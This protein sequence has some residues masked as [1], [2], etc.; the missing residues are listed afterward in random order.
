MSALKN[1]ARQPAQSRAGPLALHN[2]QLQGNRMPSRLPAIALAIA[3]PR[4]RVNCPDYPTRTSNNYASSSQTA[5]I[6]RSD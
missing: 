2:T 1:W 5:Q 4:E 6:K 3:N